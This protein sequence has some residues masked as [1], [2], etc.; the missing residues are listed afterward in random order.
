MVLQ[1][2]E[3]IRSNTGWLCLLESKVCSC[4]NNDSEPQ[5]LTCRPKTHSH[6]HEFHQ[7]LSHFVSRLGG[8][9][10]QNLTVVNL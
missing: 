3:N 7:R 1:L 4:F 2:Q 8:V 9:Q 10:Q 6:L 5:A